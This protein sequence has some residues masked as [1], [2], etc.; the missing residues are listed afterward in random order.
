MRSFFKAFFASFLALIIFSIMM[1]VAFIV[2][3]SV[4]ASNDK[5]DIASRSVLILDLTRS[6]NELPEEDPIATLTGNDDGNVPGLYTVVRLLK[7]A[8][9]DD[10]ISGL[11]IKCTD[12]ANGFAASQELRSAIE[13]FKTSKKFVIA[14]GDVISPRAYFV[15]SASH[16]V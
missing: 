9:T 4:V 3:I 1:F 14:Y 5:P 15:A 2:F 12:N 8:K 11:Y 7:H 16:R 6:Y 13:D 10:N